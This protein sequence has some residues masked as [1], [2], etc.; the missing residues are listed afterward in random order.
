MNEKINYDGVK[1]GMLTVLRD[2]NGLYEGK[3]KRRSVICKC[4][5]GQEK[6]VKLKMIREGRIKS[7]G[8]L[9]IPK[10]EVKPGDKFNFWTV[11]EEAENYVS[12]KGDKGRQ[13]F[14]ECVCGGVKNINLQSLR[15]GLSKSCGCKTE[16][17]KDNRINEDSPIPKL[18]LEKVNERK[19]GHW[20]IIEEI[21]AERNKKAKIIRTVKAQCKCGYEKISK[22]NRLG[23]SEQCSKCAQEEIYNRIPIHIRE[24]NEKL[25]AVYG[26][27]RSRINNKNNPD[28]PR[29]GGRGIEIEESFDTYEKFYNW[30]LD[31]GF[32]M[33][34]GL[35][36][37]RENNNGN[38]SSDNCRW[39][40]RAEN[41]RNTSRNV[42]TWE[43]VEK[44]RSEE[45]KHLTNREISNK[46][47]V[48]TATIKDARTCFTW[49]K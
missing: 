21:S 13:F 4:D 36:I 34:K 14:V 17:K 43:L 33:N 28:Y 16:H 12:P 30:S 37:D 32:E 1:F 26:S 24:L 22:L 11:I 31:N 10:I 41:N 9:L 48:K 42:L 25:R 8:C 39:V 47:G 23:R 49:I 29:Y 44:I 15:R 40:I 35:E 19:L 46:I 20:T 3:K 5:C 2:G 38:Y 7:C 27:M 45:W 6:E 18:N